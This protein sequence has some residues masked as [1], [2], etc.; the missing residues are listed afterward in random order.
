MRLSMDDEVEGV[1]VP[2]YHAQIMELARLRFIFHQEAQSNTATGFSELSRICVGDK[3]ITYNF[4]G[5]NFWRVNDCLLK[6][7]EFIMLMP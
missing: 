4:L 3:T 5:L 6:R 1:I 2:V 7:R